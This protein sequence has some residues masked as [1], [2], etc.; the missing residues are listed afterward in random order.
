MPRFFHSIHLPILEID[1][2]KKIQQVFGLRIVNDW[3]AKLVGFF[4]PVYIYG[5]GQNL[6]YPSLIGSLHLT[7]F[8][9]G[10]LFLAIY[11]AGLRFIIV[12]MS[13]PL[14][15][16]VAKQGSKVGLLFGI[17]CQVGYYLFLIL[18]RDNVWFLL[19]AVIFQAAQIF[20]LNTI[21]FVLFSQFALK[22]HIGEDLSLVEFL[23]QLVSVIAPALGGL[24]IMTQ[25]YDLLFLISLLGIVANL[26]LVLSQE[27]MF[28][29]TSPS[30]SELLHWLTTS[31]YRRSAISF[32]GRYMN[33]A[34]LSLWPI[35]ILLF[36]GTIEKVGFIYSLSLFFAM[37]II[38]FAGVYIDHHKSKKP[39]FF[40]GGFIST[41]WLIRMSVSN[42]FLVVVVDTLDKLMASF[43]WLFFDALALKSSK[44]NKA[45]AFFTYRE[46]VMSAG[47]TVFWLIVMGLFILPTSWYYL[48]ALG[49]VGSILTLLM[50]DQKNDTPSL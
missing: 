2:S 42:V 18:S 47:G 48:F 31:N 15:K 1:R 6:T 40:S 19:P 17:F 35:Y 7:N 49:G 32:I 33:D 11:S 44:G 9:K 38:F 46:I 34:A 27:A 5:L 37:A 21:Y 41:L 50:N 22:K 45:L 14:G 20:L 12:M 13:L 25:G 26:L 23:F 39:F 28:F 10:F 30:Q 29:K 24:I 4:I 3:I 16:L 8:Q 36:V 43:H